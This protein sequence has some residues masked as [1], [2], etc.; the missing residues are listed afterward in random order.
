MA[1]H[2]IRFALAALA[3]LA[4]SWAFAAEPGVFM[5]VTEEEAALPNVTTV[6]SAPKDLTEGPEIRV[7]SP[8]D[9]GVY[10]QSFPV[11]IEFLTGENGKPVNA[12]SLKII[13]E[14]AWGI[15]ITSRLRD[16]ITPTDTVQLRFSVADQ[17]TAPQSSTVEAGIDDLLVERLTCDTPYPADLNDDNVIDAAD[18]A[19][20][21]GA[22]GPNP[23]HPADLN[24]D[25]H[26]NAADLATLLGA[27]GPCP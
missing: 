17:P 27:W 1:R 8:T 24:D 3:A 14:K 26:V 20:L 7:A 6:R 16:Y 2:T 18:L 15:D 4:A 21:L 10:D 13:Y 19:T 11:D 12:D 5:L 22:W 9:D 25:G 23:G